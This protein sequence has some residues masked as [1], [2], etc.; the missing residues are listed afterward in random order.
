MRALLGPSAIVVGFILLF[1]G[2]TAPLG[3]IMMIIG[4]IL[5]IT[6]FFGSGSSGSGNDG[7]A[8]TGGHISGGRP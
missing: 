6:G 4:V 7:T 8:G 1:A 3:I 5:L 2:Y